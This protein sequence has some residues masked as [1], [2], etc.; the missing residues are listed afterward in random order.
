MNINY[1][2]PYSVEKNIG[3]AYNQ[4]CE[5]VPE[6]DWIC[7]RD[8][9]TMFLT[10]DWGEF[11]MNIAFRAK[12]QGYSLI[13]C[14][15]NRLSTTSQQLV[16]GAYNQHDIRYHHSVAVNHAAKYGHEIQ[17]FPHVIAGSFMLFPK[18]T[19]LM[20]PFIENTVHFDTG[21][22]NETVRNGGRLGIAPGLYLYHMYR[23]WSDHAHPQFDYKHLIK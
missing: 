15:Q 22:S 1:I 21:F 5:R 2:T 17:P 13:G 3:K 16:P 4:A 14:M 18:S 12:S 20:N 19:W 11:I 10:P 6:G 7:I 9:D 23:I 8:G